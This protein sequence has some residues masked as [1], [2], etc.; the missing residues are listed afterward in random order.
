MPLFKIQHITKYQYDRLIQESMNEIRIFPLESP[1]QQ[2]LKQD[3]VITDNPELQIFF[4]YWGNKTGTFN[5]MA[6]H[7][8]LIISSM[9]LV[10]TPENADLRINFVGS[11]NEL[12]PVVN[13]NL[14]MIELCRP[15][16]VNSQSQINDIAGLMRSP[17]ESVAITINNCSD[18]IFDQFKYIPGITNIETT[19]DETLQQKAGVCQ[20]FAHILLQ[21]L[22]TMQI[23]SRYV[24]GYICPHRSGLRGEGATHAWVE[25]W[26]PESGWTGIDPT[27]KIWVTNNHVKLAVGRN[28]ADCSPAR[29]SFK[30]IANQQLSVQV[31]VDYEDGQVAEQVYHAE[32]QKEKSPLNSPHHSPTTQQ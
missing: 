2:V 23:P 31:S 13:G 9:L 14:K 16:L 26:I 10:R 30:G 18:Y 25:A 17:D 15:E 28:F 7:R 1:D 3:L 32:A 4:D 27:N 11:F 21:I 20:D 6:P 29:G 19:I 24:S 12:S 8:E 5:L 22:R